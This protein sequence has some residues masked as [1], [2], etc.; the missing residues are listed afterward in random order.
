MILQGLTWVQITICEWE[1]QVCCILYCAASTE[2]LHCIL[3]RPGR[4][5]HQAELPREP[6]EQRREGGQRHAE[7]WVVTH[8]MFKRPFSMVSLRFL[9]MKVLE[10]LSTRS[11]EILPSPVDISSN[12]SIS[13]AVTLPSTQTRMVT[14]AAWGSAAAS[15][16]GSPGASSSS[17]SPSPSWSASRCL[18]HD[19]WEDVVWRVLVI[20]D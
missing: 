9:I 14:T 15:C 7:Q 1:Q 20:V 18:Q 2:M 17:P 12:K 19:D 4:G 6:G 10:A 11:R 3:W 16:S 8:T 5:G 13:P